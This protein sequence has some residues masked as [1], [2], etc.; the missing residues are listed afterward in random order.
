M[1]SKRRESKMK[2]KSASLDQQEPF[3]KGDEKK[4]SH[5]PNNTKTKANVKKA[6]RIRDK[7]KT[8]KG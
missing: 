2:R 8:I 1:V 5:Q 4:S 7:N 6:K 3:D